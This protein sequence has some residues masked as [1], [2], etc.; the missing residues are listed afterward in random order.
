MRR[1]LCG[2]VHLSAFTYL[3]SYSGVL[4]SGASEA[5]VWLTSVSTAS[6]S[7][8][9]LPYIFF[10]LTIC[11]FIRTIFTIICGGVSEIIRAWVQ[12]KE[13]ELKTTSSDVCGQMV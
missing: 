10:I 7:R 11:I 1:S 6:T 5:T 13:Y 12:E 2:L 8:G 4:L 3:L 9:I